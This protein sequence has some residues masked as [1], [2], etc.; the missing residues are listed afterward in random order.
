MAAP[1]RGV[2]EVFP[3]ETFLRRARHQRQELYYY[4]LFRTRTQ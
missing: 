2:A 4:T 3:P 1:D